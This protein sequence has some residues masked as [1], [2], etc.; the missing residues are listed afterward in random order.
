MGTDWWPHHAGQV[1]AVNVR[2][3]PCR[4]GHWEQ[5]PRVCPRHGEAL[6][7]SPTPFPGS[8]SI[9]FCGDSYPCGFQVSGALKCSWDALPAVEKGELPGDV[10]I[11]G[12]SNQSSLVLK[13]IW[14]QGNGRGCTVEGSEVPKVVAHS[15]GFAKTPPSA[16]SLSAGQGRSGFLK[17]SL[18]P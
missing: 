16:D 3:A 18:F 10:S 17:R 7:Q 8:L 13:G 12:Y 11:D 14:L 15:A 9:L 4:T 6:G 2:Q 1:S 5:D